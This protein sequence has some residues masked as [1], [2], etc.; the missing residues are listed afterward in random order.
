MGL[1]NVESTV[2]ASPTP[3]RSVLSVLAIVFFT[4]CATQDQPTPEP[5]P[6]PSMD[7]SGFVVVP[8]QP[9]RTSTGT[10]RDAD[11]ANTPARRHRGQPSPAPAPASDPIADGFVAAHNL[12]RARVSPAANPPLPS[13]RWSNHYVG[14]R[15]Y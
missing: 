14:E 10:Q 13:V 2:P 7:G 5:E 11:R 4:A 15:P 12:H 3:S 8:S 1:A 9:T 6:E